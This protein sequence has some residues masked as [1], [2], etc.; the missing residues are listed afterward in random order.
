[1]LS[2]DI[3]ALNN[4]HDPY[5]VKKKD[6]FFLARKRKITVTKKKRRREEMSFPGRIFFFL[7]TCFLGGWQGPIMITKTGPT[8]RK[9]A[10]TPTQQ[11][12]QKK[13]A[14]PCGP[15]RSSGPRDSMKEDDKT[16]VVKPKQSGRPNREPLTSD[17]LR[18]RRRDGL[19][20]NVDRAG[21]R[22]RRRR[23]S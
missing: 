20:G 8:W 11:K 21:E 15:H 16:E 9:L 2:K 10:H 19:H 6:H 1:M 13:M 22:L 23:R 12:E 3:E 5:R 4:A 14:L 17:P 7:R 18:L